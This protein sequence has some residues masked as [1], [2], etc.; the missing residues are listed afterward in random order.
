M[1][2]GLWKK[3]TIIGVSVAIGTGTIGYQLGSKLWDNF[4]PK[5]SNES[6]TNNNKNC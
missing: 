6:N 4:E 5:Y 1:S 2:K 3:V